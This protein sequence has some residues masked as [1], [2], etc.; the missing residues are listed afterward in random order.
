MNKLFYENVKLNSPMV[1]LQ[2]D[3]TLLDGKQYKIKPKETL[4]NQMIIPYGKKRQLRLSK[5]VLRMIRVAEAYLL[6][7]FIVTLIF[8]RM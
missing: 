1:L 3:G 4:V 6:N 7:D 2:Y 5:R 8:Q